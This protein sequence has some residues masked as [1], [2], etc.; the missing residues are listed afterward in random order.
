[1]EKVFYN[2]FSGQVLEIGCGKIEPPY[3]DYVGVDL[4][5]EALRQ[6]IRKGV[7][8]VLADGENLPFQDETFDTVCCHDVLPHDPDP[9]LLLKE[10][11]RVTRDKVIIISQNFV[12]NK[13]SWRQLNFLDWIE[14]GFRMLTNNYAIVERLET[15]LEYSPSSGKG[16]AAV[17]A[18]NL[19]FVR[20][21]LKEGGVHLMKSN[22]FMYDEAGLVRGNWLRNQ[23]IRLPFF[24]HLGPMIYVI[25]RKKENGATEE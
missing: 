8:C 7:S 22:S 20:K 9:M 24:E 4:S 25:A 18:V 10:M 1:M 17:S 16:A 23:I 13:K 5:K 6:I 3:S 11:V 12:L 15:N 14:L 2:E 19:A 21:I